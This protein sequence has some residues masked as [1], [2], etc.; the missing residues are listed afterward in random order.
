[1]TEKSIF[2]ELFSLRRY[3]GGRI[4]WAPEFVSAKANVKKMWRNQQ[5]KHIIQSSMFHRRRVIWQSNKFS[6]FR[7]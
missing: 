7:I 5:K 4:L 1:M 3:A 2:T 6:K